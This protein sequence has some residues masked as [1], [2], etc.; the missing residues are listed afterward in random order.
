MASGS[1]LFSI[2]AEPQRS[3]TR[4]ATSLSRC[5]FG[6]GFLAGMSAFTALAS[7]SYFRGAG[8][9]KFVA[10]PGTFP[11]AGHAAAAISG[12]WGT[13]ASAVAQVQLHQLPAVRPR[14]A[15]WMRAA[16]TGPPAGEGGA[17]LTP[18]LF[19]LSDEDGSGRV[20]VADLKAV[21][22][23]MGASAD[24][25]ELMRRAGLGGKG[26]LDS[27]EYGRLMEMQEE[28]DSAED[29]R[30][31][32]TSE[33]EETEDEEQQRRKEFLRKAMKSGVLNR[34]SIKSKPAAFWA[35]RAAIAAKSPK[36]A[37]K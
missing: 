2:D 21:L 19:E 3:P 17:E 36:K 16:P 9:L 31:M 34:G 11:P 27:A 7:I 35:T 23:A 20:N 26:E 28:P 22:G 13:P 4:E 10:A 37:S 33:S 1:Q 5:R 30:L 25:D 14:A 18:E 12:H 32:E 6:M 15:A 29:E 8:A 24:I